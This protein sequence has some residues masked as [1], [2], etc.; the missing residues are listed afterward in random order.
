MIDFILGLPGT[1]YTSTGRHTLT[2]D[3]YH[4]SEHF[5]QKLL[6]AFAAYLS[7]PGGAQPCS[8]FES[9]LM[10]LPNIYPA[11][12]PDGVRQRCTDYDLLHN[13]VMEVAGREKAQLFSFRQLGEEEEFLRPCSQRHPIYDLSKHYHPTPCARTQYELCWRGGFCQP[14]MLLTVKFIRCKLGVEWC[15][16]MTRPLYAD[17]ISVR[18]NKA[19]S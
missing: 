15:D 17:E 19:S 9:T 8:P 4:P 18:V 14:A 13:A 1:H 12:M 6:R 3:W 2:I 16:S 11:L 10:R 7:L 5:V